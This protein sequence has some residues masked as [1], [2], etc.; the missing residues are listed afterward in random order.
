MPL[1]RNTVQAQRGISQRWEEINRSPC[2]V[3]VCIRCLVYIT[4]FKSEVNLRKL[5]RDNQEQNSPLVEMLCNIYGMQFSKG[6]CTMKSIF[7][8]ETQAEWRAIKVD[9]KPSKDASKWFT[10][11]WVSV[12]YVHFCSQC[13]K[14]MRQHRDTACPAQCSVNKQCS[15]SINMQS[16]TNT[17]RIRWITSQMH[18]MQQMHISTQNQRNRNRWEPTEAYI[19]SPIPYVV[20]PVLS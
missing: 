10:Q 5:G 15:L 12:Q 20:N 16:F 19:N 13:K 3:W 2:L 17:E 6:K 18:Q 14:H 4:A 1:H 11:L 7:F 9:I 8:S